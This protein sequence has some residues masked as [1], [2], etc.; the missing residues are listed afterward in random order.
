MNGD[1][2]SKHH[3]KNFLGPRIIGEIRGKIYLSGYSFFNDQNKMLIGAF[4]A[5]SETFEI[6][7]NGTIK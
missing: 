1:L 5:E 7:K 3:L 6:V 2:V 4:D